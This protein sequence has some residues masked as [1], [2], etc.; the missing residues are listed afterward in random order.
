M[1]A[2]ET[3]LDVEERMEKA[4][5][6]LKHNL[7]GIRTGRANPGLVDSIKADA[8]GSP[9]PLNQTPTTGAPAYMNDFKVV[10]PG[11]K[12]SGAS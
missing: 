8:H 1:S 7:S 5:D 2:D 10:E 12:P 9:T 11:K 6:M 4:L 3:L